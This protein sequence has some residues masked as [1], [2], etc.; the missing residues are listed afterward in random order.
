VLGHRQIFVEKMALALGTGPVS[1]NARQNPV[2]HSPMP[3]RVRLPEPAWTRRPSHDRPVGSTA[4]G[5]AATYIGCKIRV[6][7]SGLFLELAENRDYC[8]LL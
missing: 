8:G 1:M 5:T 6:V 3:A 4:S 7:G 2:C